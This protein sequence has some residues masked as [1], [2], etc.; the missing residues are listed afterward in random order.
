MRPGNREFFISDCKEARLLFIVR[1]KEH[2]KNQDLK[3]LAK[4]EVLWQAYIQD[5]KM[6]RRLFYHRLTEDEYRDFVLITSL[7]KIN[8]EEIEEVSKVKIKNIFE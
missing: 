4:Y 3:H 1:L 7:A 2:L 8:M 5:D 6:F